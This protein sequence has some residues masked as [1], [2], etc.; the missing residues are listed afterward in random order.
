MKTKK[1]FFI[2]TMVLIFCVLFFSNIAAQ[3]IINKIGGTGEN[4]EFQ[5]TDSNGD[6]KLVI[7]GDGKVGIGTTTP[8]YE[9]DVVGDIN[10]TGNI[11]QSG[12]PSGQH[13]VGEFYGGGI[14]F[15]VYTDP[16]NGQQHGLIASLEDLNDGNSVYWNNG[17][18]ITTNATSTWNGA[19]NT[20]TIV[21]VQGNGTYSASLC[22]N[23]TGGGQTDWYLP[24]VYEMYLL[25]N[26]AFIIDK[27]L[28]NDGNPS[29]NGLA[30]PSNIKGY[31]TST[32]YDNDQ[33]YYFLSI[34]G[35]CET[36]FKDS[37]Y[38]YRVRAVRVF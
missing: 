13:Y 21:S 17:S 25:Y 6:E 5:V 36:F 9:L 38:A 14:V 33:A 32:E 15:Y 30:N 20:A 10:C 34:Y 35:H 16:N 2:R 31:W 26:S 29:T 37:D 19:A 7:Q 22:N 27:N 12:S 28:E 8:N 1:Q 11:Y 18:Y 24:A 23:Y 3:N 4:D